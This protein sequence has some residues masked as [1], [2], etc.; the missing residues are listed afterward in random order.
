MDTY[1]VE[2]GHEIHGDAGRSHKLRNDTEGRKSGEVVM[3][4]EYPLK[5]LFGSADSKV[6]DDDVPLG[7][8]ELLRGDFRLLCVGDELRVLRVRVVLSTTLRG[9]V[10]KIVNNLLDGFLSRA[11]VS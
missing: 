2:V 9:L 5:L 3:A 6:V 8:G 10:A 7:V 4:F 1:G 11:R